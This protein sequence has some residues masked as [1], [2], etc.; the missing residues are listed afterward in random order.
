MDKEKKR[1][2]VLCKFYSTNFFI[3]WDLFTEYLL[4]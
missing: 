1:N 4:A 3:K 2:K